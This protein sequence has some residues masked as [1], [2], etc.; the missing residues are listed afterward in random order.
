MT[1]ATRNRDPDAARVV[2]SDIT[3][4]WEAI[5]GGARS[6]EARRVEAFRD[7][8]LRP[9]SPGL[10]CWMHERLVDG[11]TVPAT[12]RE[13]VAAQ[14]L[15][16]IT[17]RRS[18][19]YDAIRP[20][21]LALRDRNP[22]T[23]AIRA[24]LREV[25]TMYP[26]AVFP[27]IYFLIG[28]LTSAGTVGMV[29]LL[30]GAEMLC[31][32]EH[33]PTDELSDW[34]RAN[35]APVTAICTALVHEL[36]HYQ[37]SPLLRTATLLEKAVRE[38][39]ADFIAALITGAVP[40]AQ[41]RNTYGAAHESS[42]WNEFRQVMY[43]CESRGWLYQGDRPRDRPADLGYYLGYRICESYYWRIG[44]ARVAIRGI[45]TFTDPA[46][47]LLASGYAP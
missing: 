35:V 9:G 39:A 2:T 3:R 4:F 32:D 14:E 34:E 17:A 18:R 37:Q 10:R 29:G 33:T 43:D 36:V 42:L 11:A 41:R 46:E 8:Y 19:F 25:Q 28:R 22:G 20:N 6:G 47:F 12:L 21:T 7:L 13:Q 16:R 31:C 27:D 15:A 30:L 5:D 24:C 45:L 40:G 26:D 23:G 38:G 1:S 44:D